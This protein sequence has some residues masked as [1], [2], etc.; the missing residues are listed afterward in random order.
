MPL[1]LLHRNP[2]FLRCL[3][4]FDSLSLSVSFSLFSLYLIARRSFPTLFSPPFDRVFSTAFSRFRA[5][6]TYRYSCVPAARQHPRF[7]LAIARLLS[8]YC[9]YVTPGIPR[10]EEFPLFRLSPRSLSR[11]EGGREYRTC[12]SPSLG[13]LETSGERA[14]A[15]VVPL[16]NRTASL[17]GKDQR[18]TRIPRRRPWRNVERRTSNVERSNHAKVTT[19]VC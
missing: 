7:H 9:P 18:E 11:V 2:Y 16:C 17:P 13:K 3:Q 8:R 6:E 10:S 5:Y 14:V 12:V 4:P 15:C 1:L 19:R